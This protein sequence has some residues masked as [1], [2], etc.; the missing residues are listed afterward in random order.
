[1]KFVINHISRHNV[2]MTKISLEN[3]MNNV[4]L[5]Y[6]AEYISIICDG[7]NTNKK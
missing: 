5:I 7:F 4:I 1:M 3:Q 6:C 2:K